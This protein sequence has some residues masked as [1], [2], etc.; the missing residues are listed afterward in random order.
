MTYSLVLLNVPAVSAAEATCFGSPDCASMSLYNAVLI[1][2]L[3][4]IS[5]SFISRENAATTLSCMATFTA[6]FIPN[7]VLPIEGRAPIT[8]ICPGFSPL[9]LVSS[10]KNPVL[11]PL[12]LAPMLNTAERNL[13]PTGA[14]VPLPIAFTPSMTLWASEI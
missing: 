14:T 4:M 2:A 9:S 10:A 5:S 11:R 6:I 7:E 1:T 12:S 13:S 3:L 8:V